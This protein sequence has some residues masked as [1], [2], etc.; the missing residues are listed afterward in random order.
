MLSSICLNKMLKLIL[1]WIFKD[2]NNNS[3][4]TSIHSFHLSSA[5]IK[6]SVL[7]KYCSV[8]NWNECFFP[9]TKSRTK[10]C[11]ILIL[12]PLE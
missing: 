8:K 6:S 1:N 11:H 7:S 5:V 10:T 3:G 2:I 9:V 4:I 12:L